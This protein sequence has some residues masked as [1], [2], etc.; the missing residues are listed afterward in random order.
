MYG[1]G[2]GKGGGKGWVNQPPM[3][4]GSAP[5]DSS[6]NTSVPNHYRVDHR[7]PN[8]VNYGSQR[9]DSSYQNAWRSPTSGF[10]RSPDPNKVLTWVRMNVDPAFIQKVPKDSQQ[11]EQFIAELLAS[12]GPVCQMLMAGMR[13]KKFY[14]T[15]MAYILPLDPESMDQGLHYLLKFMRDT[16]MPKPSWHTQ[17]Q[18]GYDRPLQRLQCSPLDYLIHPQFNKEF[19]DVLKAQIDWDPN[20]L[21]GSLYIQSLLD[22]DKAKE[23]GAASDASGEDDEDD[24]ME[25]ADDNVLPAA[26]SAHL[27]ALLAAQK[28]EMDNLKKMITKPQNVR[29][30]TPTSK[31]RKKSKKSPTQS[32]EKGSPAQNLRS[33]T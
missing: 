2:K 30:A 11:Y 28:A 4:S 21:G 15:T 16:L 27:M 25:G 3:S 26:D 29:D 32:S 33:S 31:A 9:D 6:S 1:K 20:A 10:L 13:G 8:D 23:P 5:G 12:L 24:N 18:G 14:G 22:A 17:G 19:L 7:F